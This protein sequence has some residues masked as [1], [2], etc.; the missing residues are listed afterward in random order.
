VY[1]VSKYTNWVEFDPFWSEALDFSTRLIPRLSPVVVVEADEGHAISIY[2]KETHPL[3]VK[4]C[5]ASDVA[6]VLNR[7]P[8]EHLAGLERVNLLGGASKQDRVASID[9]VSYGCYS[10][11]RIWLHAFPRRQMSRWLR[12][13]PK[14]SVVQEYTR[15]GAELAPEDGGWR[16]RF[17]ED[18]LRRFYLRDVLL[19]ELGHHVDRFNESKDGQSKE[20]YANWFASQYADRVP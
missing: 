17:S 6:A 4:P 7:M 5:T 11:G 16:F 9:L 8:R 15:V 19:H 3:F 2:E 13:L 12:R 1:S 18:S 14:P 10:K 20:R